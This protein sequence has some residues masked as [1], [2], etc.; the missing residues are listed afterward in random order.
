MDKSPPLGLRSEQGDPMSNDGQISAHGRD[1]TAS[2]KGV[3]YTGSDTSQ[4][5]NLFGTTENS[6]MEKS[7]L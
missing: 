4:Y 6:P 5:T 2:S 3:R 1:D 7:L